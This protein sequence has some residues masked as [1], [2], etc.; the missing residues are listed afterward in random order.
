MEHR[1][2]RDFPPLDDKGRELYTPN[3]VGDPKIVARGIELY[4]DCKGVIEPPMRAQFLRILDEE[5]R[6]LGDVTVS[7]AM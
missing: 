1:D 4:V 7:S 5:L 6:S 2:D 3:Y